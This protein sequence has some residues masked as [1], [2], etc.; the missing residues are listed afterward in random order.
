MA[1]EWA[2]E[3]KPS[4]IM[5]ILSQI[6]G[7]I[8]SKCMY[9]LGSRGTKY[10]ES[11]NLGPRP[12]KLCTTDE[13]FKFKISSYHQS[14]TS[15]APTSTSTYPLFDSVIFEFRSGIMSAGAAAAVATALGIISSLFGIGSTTY[16]L[17]SL[18]EKAFGEGGDNRAAIKIFVGLDVN[19]LSGA[20]GDLPDA[21]L[22]NMGGQFLGMVA[23]PGN[24]SVYFSNFLYK[25][26]LIDNDLSTYRA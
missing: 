19:G 12:S 3:D 10:W 14:C 21:R 18:Q 9:Y 7:A 17:V 15:I 2:Q 11:I 20:G 13:R 25:I 8:P 26:C 6:E 5:V 24:V 16:S 22:F 23:D 1:G 4:C